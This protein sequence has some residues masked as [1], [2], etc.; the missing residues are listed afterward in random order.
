MISLIISSRSSL[1]IPF[2]P[3]YNV[4]S[5]RASVTFETVK[6]RLIAA[7]TRPADTIVP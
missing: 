4:S 1:D 2:P 3:I 7:I 5:R 6:A